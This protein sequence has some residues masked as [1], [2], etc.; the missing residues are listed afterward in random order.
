MISMACRRHPASLAELD[1]Q[2]IPCGSVKRG[3]SFR[4]AWGLAMASRRWK[5]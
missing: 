1:T 5:V 4:A 2:G 3:P